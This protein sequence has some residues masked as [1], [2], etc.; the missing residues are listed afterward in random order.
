M[1]SPPIQVRS[2][3]HVTTVLLCRPPHNFVDVESMTAL[4]DTLDA[5]DADAHCRCVVLASEGKS[6]CAGADFTGTAGGAGAS[7]SLAIYRQAMRMFHTRKPIVAA[8]QGATIGA[9]AGLALIADFRIA[10][11]SSRFSV[12]FNR[13]G[14]HPGFGLS[15]TLPRLVGVQAAARLFYTGERIRG[16]RMLELGLADELVPEDG[17]LA[18]AQALAQDIATSAPQAVQSTRETLRLGLAEQVAAMNAREVGIQ[19]PQFASPDF[20]EGVRAASE[21]RLP[22]FTGEP[23]IDRKAP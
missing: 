17:L 23:F 6:F 20:Q 14:F 4:A 8:L 9:G 1:T 16:D 13:L 15:C 12:N 10:S 11:P 7:D 22:V 2:Q 19:Q 18:R 3:G 21:R 5:L